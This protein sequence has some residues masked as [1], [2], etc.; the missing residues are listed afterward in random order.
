MLRNLWI[1]A[2][3]LCLPDGVA[4]QAVSSSLRPMVRPM[5]QAGLQGAAVPAPAEAETPVAAAEA[6][7][8]GAILPNAGAAAASEVTPLPPSRLAPRP[9]ASALRLAEA[10]RWNEAM[11]L[12]VRVDPLGADL[13][14]WVRLRAGQGTPEQVRDFLAT[15]G[16]WPGLEYLRRQSEA[17]FDTA[18]DA[19]VLAFYDGHAPQT[20]GGVLRYAAALEAAGKPSLAEA[21]VVQAWRNFELGTELSEAFL[22]RYAKLL[23]A[24]HRARLDM[25]LWRGRDADVA[26]MQPLVG[27]QDWALAQARQAVQNGHRGAASMIA[28]LPTAQRDDAGLA[29]DRFRRIMKSG[30]AEEAA[31]L[32]LAR[33]EIVGGL[34]MPERWA[35]ERRALARQLMRAGEAQLAYQLASLHQ[36]ESGSNFADLEWL[37]GYLALRYLDDPMLALQHFERFRDAVE[38]PISIGRAGYWIGRAAEAIGDADAAARG[39]VL[40]AQ[41][42]T[43]FYGLLAAERAGLPVDDDLAGDEVF[44]DWRTAAFLQRP[45]ARVARALLQAGE[46]GLAERFYTHL[47]ES[48]ER[49]EIGQMGAMLEAM[50]RPHLQVMVGKRSARAGHTLPGPYYALHEM[51]F[52]DLPI[53]REMALAIARRESEFD[54]R[55]RSGVGA[56]GL[57]QL[58]PATAKEVAAGLGLPYDARRLGEDWRYNATLGSAYLAHVAE[59]FEGNVIMVA[60]AYNAGP[61]RPLRWMEE[62]GNPLAGE[63][64][65]VDWIEHIPFRETRNYVMR[66]AESLPVYRARLGGDPLPIPFSAELSGHTLQVPVR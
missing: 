22:D 41:Y 33:S 25:A 23:K 5:V 38:T 15:H 50:N 39:Y 60:A 26:L 54:P 37:S 31:A 8:Q 9:L 66:V 61:S 43:S 52:M 36:L 19:Q 34:G 4:A 48:L 2:L 58:M 30:T 27:E 21:L 14:E 18:T 57:M 53:A 49:T 13:I 44:D 11:E 12:A 64:D 45:V 59:Q 65:M 7:P 10:G 35:S 55:V 42:Q 6:S 63:V 16:D 1:I 29:Y 24:H 3:G 62:F 17:G 20:G 56:Q 32:M 40:G 28:S 46:V 47:A 51:R